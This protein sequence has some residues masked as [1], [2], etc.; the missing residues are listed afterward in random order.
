LLLRRSIPQYAQMHRIVL[1]GKMFFA[2]LFSLALLLHPPRLSADQPSAPTVAA[3]DRYV[4]TAETQM[5]ADLSANHGFLAL[6]TF[7]QPRQSDTRESLKRGRTFVERSRGCESASCTD[8]PGGLIHDWTATVFVPGVTLA[9]TLE[10]LQDYDRDAE[11][12]A[13][14]VVCSKLLSRDANRFRVFLRLKQTHVTTV[15]LDTEYDIAYLTIDGTHAASNSHSIRIAEI[16]KAGTAGERAKSPSAEN[17]F[18]WRLNSYWRFQEADGGVYIECRA[19]S[20]TR[21]VPTGLKWLIAPYIENIP[22]ESLHFTL[23]ATREALLDK[24]ASD[25]NQGL[26]K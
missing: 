22:R 9:Q 11:Y 6:D 25:K 12:Y 2:L 21:D 14:Q 23:S 13:P 1:I 24:F 3:F 19:I 20:L 15:V 18:L 7:S 17:G 5:N 16:E 10:A 8:I 26:K 4:K